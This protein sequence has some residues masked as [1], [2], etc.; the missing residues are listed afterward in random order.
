MRKSFFLLLSLILIATIFSPYIVKA[1]NTK[2]KVAAI[3]SSSFDRGC[4]NNWGFIQL[5]QKTLTNTYTFS[6]KDTS[7]SSMGIAYFLDKWKNNV[8]GKGYN[9]LLLYAGLN[10]LGNND[11]LNAYKAGMETILSEAKAEN[12][13]IVIVGAQPFKG[14]SSWTEPWG[15][16]LV[17]NNQSLS[18]DSRVDK[19]IDVMDLVDKDRDGKIDDGLSGDHLHLNPAGNTLL[20][21]AILEQAYGGPSSVS[22]VNP[23]GNNT[24]SVDTIFSEIKLEIKKPDTKINIPGLNFSEPDIEKMKITDDAGNVWLTIPYLGEYIAAV[25]KYGIFI[26]SLLA[27]F[28]IISGGITLMTGGSVSSKS[29][30]G[31]SIASGVNAAKKRITMSVMGLIIAV[32]SYSL[33]YLINPELV[34]FRNLRIL[35]VKGEP[36]SEK[37]D[38]PDEVSNST[39]GMENTS[40]LIIQTN[41]PNKLSANEN[42][43]PYL[44]G[45]LPN[46]IKKCSA[47][48]LQYTAQK[49]DE[50]HICVGSCHCAYTTSHFLNYIGC[51]IKYT[52]SAPD[53]SNYAKN[54]NW[55]ETEVIKD[56][57]DQNLPIG[58]AIMTD[59]SKKNILHAGISLGNGAI[60]DSS[61]KL[62]AFN[63]VNK[64]TGNTCPPVRKVKVG[65]N[66]QTVSPLFDIDPNNSNKNCTGCSLIPSE[67][68]ITG[69][70]ADNPLS[71]INQPFYGSL[72][73]GTGYGDSCYSVQFWAI[74]KSASAASEFNYVYTP[75][76]IK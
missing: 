7:L 42:P 35:Y 53:I 1:A 75:T 56:S 60:F 9:E 23:Q 28:G 59:S 70:W 17:T 26:I 40:K 65:E 44:I 57:N 58:L 12:M 32:T 11:G 5:L 55:I 29:A 63:K 72:I 22:T 50:Q 47:E 64:A 10:G 15:G 8:K 66:N 41:V 67:S 3:G 71:A 45:G 21:K 24:V 51:Q 27:V 76:E 30:D 46:S 62:E 52:A 16:N 69:R 36:F 19:Y 37:E 14:Y 25:Y 13:R 43:I 61:G 73:Q 4:N 39:N 6:C 18:Q 33:L 2:I 49:L 54:L 38:V 20:Y 74:R 34:Q 48:A 31:K 68:P